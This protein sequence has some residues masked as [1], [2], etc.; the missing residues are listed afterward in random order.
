MPWI[1]SNDTLLS[2]ESVVAKEAANVVEGVSTY[3]IFEYVIF[4]DEVFFNTW[5]AFSQTGDIGL[6]CGLILTTIGTRLVM[7]PIQFYQ[8]IS[9]YKLKLLQPD[10]DESMANMK[11]YM[12]QGNKEATKTERAR[13]KRLRWSHGV[14]PSLNLLNLFQIPVH[15]V[16]I[17]MINRLSFDFYINPA[18]MTDGFLWFTD[19]SQPDA[20]FVLPI[21]A[22][23][24]QYLNIINSNTAAANPTFRKF[25]KL[26]KLM[27]VI[28]IPIWMTLPAA[29]NVYWIIFSS[30]QLVLLNLLRFTRV[31][32]HLGINRF[33]PGTKLERLNVKNVRAV[34]QA[35]VLMQPPSKK[36]IEQTLKRKQLD[37]LS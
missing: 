23:T 26:L 12:K 21:L 36:V 25:Q 18:I 17:S 20:F 10:I 15:I 11:T 2:V 4:L 9:S 14:Y 33:L 19:L 35:K 8:Q 31:R 37:Q 6:G 32:Q 30:F 3:G 13:M 27:P 29:F 24:V 22:G 1:D 28:S 34:Q 7:L 5:M 16:F